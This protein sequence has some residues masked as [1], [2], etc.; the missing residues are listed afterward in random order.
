MPAGT[1]QAFRVHQESG[2]VQGRLEE[3]DL[4]ALS[5]GEVVIRVAYSGV[6][7]KDA[8]AATGAGKILRRF[9]MVAG[10]DLAGHVD[11]STD[12]RFQEGDAVLVAGC[13]LGEIHDGGY[14]EYARVPAS[15]VVP[16]PAG[17]SLLEAM[18]LGTAGFTAGIAIHQM[19]HN[20]QHPAHGPLVVT[21]ATGGV[22]SLAISMLAGRGYQVTALTGKR[23]ADAYLRG[24]GAAEIQYRDALKMGQRPLEEALWGGAVDNLGGEVL[25]WL[26][27]TVKPRGNIAC[28]GLAASMELSTTVL[29]FILRGINLLGIHSVQVDPEFRRRIWERLATD[30]RPPSL[31]KIVRRRIALSDLP[32]VFPA[33]LTGEIIGRTVVDMGA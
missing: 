30:L 10:I 6:N 26:T 21:G 27:R 3:I 22:G 9:P 24:L 2:V 16:L 8:L 11:S 29:P 23:Q 31:D 7:Y 19:E 25:S 17:L 15:C 33:Y 13:G 18:A 20:G 1:F 32:S 5:P 14:A 12:G 28:I 4:A